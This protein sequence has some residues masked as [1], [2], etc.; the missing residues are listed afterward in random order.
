MD[1]GLKR[2]GTFQLSTYFHVHRQLSTVSNVV[3]DIHIRAIR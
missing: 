1:D 3:L 2:V